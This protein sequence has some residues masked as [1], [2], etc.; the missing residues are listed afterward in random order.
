MKVRYNLF[1]RLGTDSGNKFG[2]ACLLCFWTKD[3]CTDVVY[4]N[5]KSKSDAHMLI[6]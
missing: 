5:A 6:G 3:L 1:H 4:L 2:P